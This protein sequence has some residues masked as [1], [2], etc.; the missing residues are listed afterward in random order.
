MKV[1]VTGANGFL[2]GYVIRNL[3][4]AG[5][6]AYGMLRQ[7]ANLTNL[8]DLTLK[9]IYGNL[10]NEN[11]V[12]EAVKG[13]Q[14]VIHAAA[15]TSP[16]ASWDECY[17][18][19]VRASNIL[20]NAAINHGCETIIYVS[21]A[22]TIGYGDEMN[23]GHEELSMSAEF[24]VSNYAYSKFLAEELFI[25]AAQTGKIR[26]VIVNPSFM[27]GYNPV[28]KSSA[29]I[30]RMFAKNK[31]ILVPPGGKNFVYVNDVAKAICNA[32]ELGEN[33]QRYLLVNRN[34]S[35]EAFFEKLNNLTGKRKKTIMIN[36]PLMM[37]AGHGGSFL[38]AFGV[39][40]SL[41][42]ENARILTIK[43]YYTA[44]KAIKLLKMPQTDL[45]VAIMEG[46]RAF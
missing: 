8:K 45:D 33:G 5:Y 9:C 31:L 28:G 37:V 32:I 23:P 3:N 12:N 38:R 18:V 21:T 4:I 27:L 41:S 44:D 11:V 2:A 7:N 14:V 36:T 42:K 17:K 19:N 46:W 24:R 43:N 16:W 26:V 25:D 20:I 13:K 1:L 34:L 29:A 6:E 30:F 15:V 35:Y 39:K 10:N 22:N 40:S